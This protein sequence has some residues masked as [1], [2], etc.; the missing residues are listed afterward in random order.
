VGARI[1]TYLLER[2]RLVY[3][4]EIE[5]NYHIFYQLLAGAP[6]TE[7]KNL[8][9][10]HAS[11]FNYLN[12][13]G[14]DSVAIRGVDDAEEF[15]NTQKALSVVGIAVERQ[16]QIFKLLAALLHIGNMDITASRTEALLADDDPSLVMATDL[17]GID[18]SMFKKWLI[19]KQITTKTEK[20]V[21]SLQASQANIVK[22]SVAKFI[23]ASLFDWLVGVTNESLTNEGVERRVESFIGVLVSLFLSFLFRLV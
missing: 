1:R 3:Q 14:N 9:L 7:R 6:S 4:P 16:W 17:L 18:R 22:D 2:S 15:R 11:H 12:Q 23:Y 8:G 21:S 19:K 13:G 10:E 20:I 5:R